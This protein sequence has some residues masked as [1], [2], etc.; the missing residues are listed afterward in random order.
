MAK[1]SKPK[2]VIRPTTCATYIF[3]SAKAAVAQQKRRG[4]T[5]MPAKLPTSVDELRAL[6][7]AR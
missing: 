1:T 4:T 7:V 2:H 3:G 6:K 5:R